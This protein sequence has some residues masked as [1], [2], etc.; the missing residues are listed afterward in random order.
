MANVRDWKKS[1]K[2]SNLRFSLLE[3][4]KEARSSTVEQCTASREGSGGFI[5]WA[6]SK[7]L[8][9]V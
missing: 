8:C 5:G 2:S 1:A 9:M 6:I 4:I 3:I 7:D